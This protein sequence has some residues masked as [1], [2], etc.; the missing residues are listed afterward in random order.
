[1][2]EFLPNRLRHINSSKLGS[3]RHSVA[4]SR[5]GEKVD[6]YSKKKFFQSKESAISEMKEVFYEQKILH[7][8]FPEN[9]P[10]RSFSGMNIHGDIGSV[11]QKVDMDKRG[12]IEEFWKSYLLLFAP[13]FYIKDLQEIMGIMK[14]YGILISLDT[15]TINNFKFEDD[16]SGKSVYIDDLVKNLYTVPLVHSP[17]QLD[18]LLAF[19]RSDDYKRLRNSPFDAHLIEQKLVNY[20]RRILSLRAQRHA[21]KR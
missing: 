19:V 3:G 15:G 11:R 17:K 10:N 16:N 2:P 1:M 8:L 13:G 9:F 18:R 21:T 5:S 6:V 14:K 7:L 4:F 12:M 20:G